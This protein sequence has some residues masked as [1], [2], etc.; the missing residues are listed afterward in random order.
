M[1]GELRVALRI[2]RDMLGERGCCCNPRDRQRTASGH[3]APCVR[4]C[5]L[6]A[7]YGMRI[8]RE[9]AS[10]LGTAPTSTAKR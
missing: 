5:R 8:D 3:T 4:A 1:T 9:P 2:M 10:R 6:L 7:R